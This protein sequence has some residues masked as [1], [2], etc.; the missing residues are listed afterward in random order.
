MRCSTISAGAA[1]AATAAA[2]FGE[3]ERGA[4]F[5]APVGLT[6]LASSESVAV[7]TT[8]VTVDAVVLGF[9][10][11]GSTSALTVARVP[12]APRFFEPRFPRP[13]PP[14]VRP[15][16]LRRA[17][18]PFPPPPPTFRSFTLIVL[19]AAVRELRSVMAMPCVLPRWASATSTPLR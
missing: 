6:V 11:Y 10:S 4:S 13:R 8:G 3:G 19:S 1:A 15:A 16:V 7:P 2:A 5:V 14:R 17:R 9:H 18:F 12:P